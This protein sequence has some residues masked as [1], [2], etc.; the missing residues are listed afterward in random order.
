MTLH[1]C[2]NMPRTLAAASAAGWS[3]LGAAGDGHAAMSVEDVQ[4]DRP[5]ILVMGKQGV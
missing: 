4:V 5:T 2:H 1:S 3:V